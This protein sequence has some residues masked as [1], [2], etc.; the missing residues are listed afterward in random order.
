MYLIQDDKKN[1]YNLITN[2]IYEK[3]RHLQLFERAVQINVGKVL[4]HDVMR[5]A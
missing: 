4:I 3:R 5:F 1:V 2:F